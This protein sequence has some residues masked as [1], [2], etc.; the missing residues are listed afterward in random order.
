[1]LTEFE[2]TKQFLYTLYSRFLKDDD[3][4]QDIMMLKYLSSKLEYMVKSNCIKIFSEFGFTK[5]HSSIESINADETFFTKNISNSLLDKI[6]NSIIDSVS[7][8]TKIKL[9]KVK[10][11]VR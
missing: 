1:M 2:C 7:T 9:K 10:S 5:K 4:Y 11:L 6:S 3:L 8:K